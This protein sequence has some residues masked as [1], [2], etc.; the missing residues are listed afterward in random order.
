MNKKALLSPKTKATPAVKRAKVK[1]ATPAATHAPAKT[2]TNGV[3][4][5]TAPVVPRRDATGH[6]NPRL[7]SHLRRRSR[8]DRVDNRTDAFVRGTSSSDDLAEVLGEEAVTAMTGGDDFGEDVSDRVVTEEF[9][10]PFITS[11]GR[12]EFGR[13]VDASNP[14]GSKR[15]PF[16]KV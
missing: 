1:L 7:A 11:T 14:R 4:K 12:K 5:A 10:G 8:A 15:E 6:L 16:P 2:K 3:A 9:G 13:G